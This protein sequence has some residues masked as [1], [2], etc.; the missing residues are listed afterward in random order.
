MTND[1]PFS[2]PTEFDLFSADPLRS[3]SQRVDPSDVSDIES[4]F[5]LRD[6][7]MKRLE[8]DTDSVAVV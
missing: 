2:E 1:L 6:R 8:L 4:K 5:S 7:Q 3:V